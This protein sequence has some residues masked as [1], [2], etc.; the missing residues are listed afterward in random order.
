MAIQGKVKRGSI[1]WMHFE[2]HAGQEQGFWR[3][4]LVLSN[5]IISATI[6]LAFVVPITT[7]VKGYAYEVPVPP[8]IEVIGAMAGQDDLDMLSGVA[9]TFHGKSVDLSACNA[10]VI[11][12]IDPESDFYK[13]VEDNVLTFILS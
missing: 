1:V 9:L 7:E 3:P 2:P 8:G 11:G 10:A 12:E 4:A 5:G 13:E 6:P